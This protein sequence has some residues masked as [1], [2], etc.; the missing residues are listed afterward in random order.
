MLL[1]AV[2]VCFFSLYV[3]KINSKLIYLTTNK[4]VLKYTCRLSFFV[5]P[6]SIKNYFASKYYFHLPT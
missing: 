1:F 2:Q 6:L 5:T 4:F 3:N